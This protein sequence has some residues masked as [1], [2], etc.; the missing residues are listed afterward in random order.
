M[1]AIRSYYVDG[2]LVAGAHFDQMARQRMGLRV[3]V[4]NIFRK[5]TAVPAQGV[6]VLAQRLQQFRNNFV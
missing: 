3:A 4:F 6:G 2:L 5:V 1:Y